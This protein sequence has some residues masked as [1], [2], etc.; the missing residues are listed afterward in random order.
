MNDIEA[1]T[2]AYNQAMIAKEHD[3]VPIGAIVVKDNQIIGMGY[4]Q[5]ETLN[6]VTA[7][8]EMIAIKQACQKLQT[9]H[10][11]GCTLYSTLEPCMMCSGAIIQS[12]ISRVVFGASGV[13]WDGI[14]RYVK[15]HHF[16]HYPDIVSGIYEKEC[17]SLLSDYFK[18]KR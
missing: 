14:S 13:R 8:A 15:D 7:H 1:M 16:N 17:C 18:T 9:W 6:D 3:E 11:N 5:K 12:R 2:I 4:N 10:L